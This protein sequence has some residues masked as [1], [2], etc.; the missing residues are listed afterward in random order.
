M[1]DGR[2]P[3]PAHQ[4][5]RAPSASPYSLTIART[6]TAASGTDPD[7]A[8]ASKS[9]HRADSTTAPTAAADDHR[10][11][12]ARRSKPA[13]FLAAPCSKSASARWRAFQEEHDHGLG[14]IRP[15]L[16]VETT[17][18]VQDSLIDRRVARGRRRGLAS[19]FRVRHPS[20]ENRKPGLFS[21]PS[22]CVSFHGSRRVLDYRA[23]AQPRSETWRA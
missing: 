7:R 8:I 19:V 1:S 13:S 3:R 2:Y 21:S 14:D 20:A 6:R 18:T 17:Q 22:A 23:R 11:W 10:M 4:A 9:L 15:P 5:R 16:A 12:L